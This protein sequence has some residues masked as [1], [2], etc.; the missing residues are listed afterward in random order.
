MNASARG[1]QAR[2][3]R[4]LNRARFQFNRGIAHG[5]LQENWRI[6]YNAKVEVNSFHAA[7]AFAFEQ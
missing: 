6:K 1:R 2:D 5:G 4:D 7:L 3:R